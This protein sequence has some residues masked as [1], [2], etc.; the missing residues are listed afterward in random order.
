MSSAPGN[1]L[2][3]T[4]GDVGTGMVALAYSKG[5]ES[6]VSGLPGVVESKG[7]DGAAAMLGGDILQQAYKKSVQVVV[8]GLPV[9]VR[10]KRLKL[11]GDLLGLGVLLASYE[12]DDEVVVEQMK[13]LL[14]RDNGLELTAGDVGNMMV[15]LA[16]SKGDENAVSGLPGVVESRGLDGAAAMLGEDI[17]RQAYKKRVQVVV[18]GLPVFVR[19]KG[20]TLAIK[21]LGTAIV[22]DFLA[23]GCSAVEAVV[24]V[25]G[26]QHTRAITSDV[27]MVLSSQTV[28]PILCRR[29]RVAPGD[30]M[31]RQGFSGML[32]GPLRKTGV[33]AVRLIFRRLRQLVQDDPSALTLKMIEETVCAIVGCFNAC[34]VAILRVMPP[35][36]FARSE[37][38]AACLKLGGGITLRTT[39]QLKLPLPPDSNELSMMDRMAHAGNSLAEI[40]AAVND[41]RC[42]DGNRAVTDVW[43]STQRSK[44]SNPIPMNSGE[45]APPYCATDEVLLQM[46]ILSAQKA[47]HQEIAEWLN[48]NKR[49]MLP[50]ER[51]DRN[52]NWVKKTFSSQKKS[53][54]LAKVVNE[55]TAQAAA[56]KP[57]AEVHVLQASFAVGP[58]GL[59]LE[60]QNNKERG[61]GGKGSSQIQHGAIIHG[62]S[63]GRGRAGG[64]LQRI[65]W[66]GL[67]MD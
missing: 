41:G 22:G 52:T 15:A 56:A 19:D 27:E 13:A 10:N 6:A 30:I 48:T 8:D 1:G 34:S 50:I 31:L 59:T 3:L 5:D 23:H 2:E 39:P 37:S 25:L 35:P 26:L 29:L 67:W 9:F 11:A 7:L 33:I 54:R 51:C 49:S 14:A 46:S 17:L 12:N 55:A 45:R 4:A 57:A 44:Q 40:A 16:Y 18:D 65:C 60:T 42:G 32:D 38:A 20:L 62:R 66:W 53:G 24:T 61:G 64:D 43:I 47:R 36:H 58:T 28:F 63:A 21:L